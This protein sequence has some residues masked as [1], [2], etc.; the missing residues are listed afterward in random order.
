M[1]N[2]LQ[3]LVEKSRTKLGHPTDGQ[4]MAVLEEDDTGDSARPGGDPT[5]R[6]LSQAGERG[7]GP[8]PHFPPTT[9][10]PPAAAPPHRG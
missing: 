5:D 6:L 3:E 1:A 2:G 8:A 4:L 9:P 7:L 10:A